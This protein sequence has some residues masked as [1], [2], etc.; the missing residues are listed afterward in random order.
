MSTLVYEGH[1][2]IEYLFVLIYLFN[3]LTLT[4]VSLHRKYVSECHSSEYGD[5]IR[6]T[7]TP[8][9]GCLLRNT[10]RMHRQDLSSLPVLDNSFRKVRFPVGHV[11]E[12]PPWYG[13]HKVLVVVTPV[14]RLTSPLENPL[15]QTF[16]CFLGLVNPGIFD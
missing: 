7:V 9:T 11:S 13:Q 6:P 10:F 2:V 15:L 12:T 16:H 14:F 1:G 5:S 4:T 8:S 3:P